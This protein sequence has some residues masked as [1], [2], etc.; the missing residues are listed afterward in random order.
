MLNRSKLPQGGFFLFLLLGMLISAS[1]SILAARWTDGLWNLTVVTTL[2]LV[3]GLFLAQSRFPA[4]I[5]HLFSL[6]YGLFTISYLVGRMIDRPTWRE[7]V[8]ELGER[9]AAWFDKAAS[10]GTS[11]DSLMFVLLLTALFWLLG[12]IAAWYTFRRPRLWRVLLPI[13]LTLLVNYYVYTDPR[14][15]PR[16]T[17]S[18]A[19]FV[20]AFILIALLYAVR[21]NVYLHELEWQ[22]C[23]VN[24]STEVRFDFARSG[25]ILAAAA[26]VVMALAPGAQAGPQLGTLWEGLEDARNSVRDTV[27]RLFS[28][29]DARGVGGGNPFTGRL[30]LGGPRELGENPILDVRARG[31]RYWQAMTYDRYTGDDW[32]NSDAERLYLEPGQSARATDWLMRREMTQTVR[33]YFQNSSQLFAAP[34]P[35]RVPELRTRVN[36]ST[37]DGAAMSPSAFYAREALDPGATYRIVSSISRADPD[38]LRAAGQDYPDWATRR[39]LQLPDTVTERTR[40]LAQEITVGHENAFDKA[41]AIEQYLRQNLYYDLSVPAPPEGQD[42]VDF[43]LFDLEGGYCDYYASS[44]VVLARSVGIPARFVAGYAQDEYDAEVQ[45]YRVR[46]KNGHSWP[47]VFFPQYGWI[48]F[49]PTVVIAPINRPSSPSESDAATG[50]TNSGFDENLEDTLNPDDRRFFQEPEPESGSALAAPPEESSRTGWS[51]FTILVAVLVVAALGAGITYWATEMRGMSG[52]NSIERVYARM[53]RFAA[54]LGIP[55]PPDQTPYER[56]EALTTL[57]P[58]GESSIMGIADM[59]VVE[60]FGRGNEDGSAAESLWSLLRPVLWKTWFQKRWSR[61]R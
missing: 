39:Y 55:G 42:F 57:V 11:R 56:A 31:G 23:H 54:R 35:V 44:F 36:V 38:S 18:L 41:Q 58:A 5:A 45:A 40:A 34:E 60:R 27:N 2:A 59:Y 46:A 32:R 7:R 61:L 1:L 20:A 14:I 19:P 22:S 51:T 49:E 10:G 13:G 30:V 9:A 53:W 28:S 21:T 3:V 12:H 29:L 17:T 25:A 15:A 16:S 52:L 6:I 50:A 37:E 43:V 4:V 24:Y 33:I 8:I 26:L 48:Q 47:E